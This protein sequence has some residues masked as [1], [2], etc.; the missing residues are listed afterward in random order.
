MGRRP[1]VR[2]RWRRGSPFRHARECLPRPRD[3]LGRRDSPGLDQGPCSVPSCPASLPK[4]SRGRRAAASGCLLRP[5]LS[6]PGASVSIRPCPPVHGAAWRIRA[7]GV[8]LPMRSATLAHRGAPG[9][10]LPQ[11]AVAAPAPDFHRPSVVQ[12]VGRLLPT[13]WPQ[14]HRWTASEYARH[15]I[16]TR[17]ECLAALAAVGRNA[18]SAPRHYRAPPPPKGAGGGSDGARDTVAASV[19]G[20]T[21]SRSTGEDAAAPAPQAGR[22][23]R[24]PLPIQHP[25]SPSGTRSVRAMHDSGHDRSVIRR[26]RAPETVRGADALRECRATG[27]STRRSCTPVLTQCGIARR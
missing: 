4:V 6:R 14:G 5:I 9:Q 17:T 16:G 27:R 11:A 24:F 10:R 18:D 22:T 7:V 3:R 21:A 20:R 12:S 23:C 1:L 25:S 8:H 15:Q 13:T 2:R 19:L 26:H